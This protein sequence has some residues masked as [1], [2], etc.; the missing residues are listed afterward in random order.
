MEIGL[1][2]GDKVFRMG[3]HVK[4]SLKNGRA[5]TGNIDR[6][7]CHDVIL[8]EGGKLAAASLKDIEAVTY[9]EERINPYEE[10]ERLMSGKEMGAGQ[11]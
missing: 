10:Y 7:S 8:D 4:V 11:E 6:L 3:E 2:A 1:L 5:Y 9:S